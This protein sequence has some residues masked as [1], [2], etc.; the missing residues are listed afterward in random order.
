MPGEASCLLSLVSRKGAWAGSSAA[1]LVLYALV[2]EANVLER[3]LAQMFDLQND[4]LVPAKVL[5]LH[6]AK[7]LLP[8]EKVVLMVVIQVWEQKKK[9]VLLRTI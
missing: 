7:F 3:E 9:V 6:A 1:L 8:T 5:K 2:L 4:A